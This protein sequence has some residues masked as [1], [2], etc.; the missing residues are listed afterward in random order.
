MAWRL[1]GVQIVLGWDGKFA[2]GLVLGFFSISIL[3]LVR[4]RSVTRG[5]KIVLED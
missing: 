1:E 5:D 3:F 2:L 4:L